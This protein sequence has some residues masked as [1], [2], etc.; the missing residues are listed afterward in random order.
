[1]I[2]TVYS[3]KFLIAEL[4][5]SPFF[6]FIKRLVETCF[7]EGYSPSRIRHGLG[8]IVRFVRWSSLRHL[9]V[10]NLR[11]K[12]VDEFLIAME[13][14]I[15]T[16]RVSGLCYFS[17]RFFKIVEDEVGQNLLE[18][19]VLNIGPHVKSQTDRYSKYLR[20]VRGLSEQSISR[21]ATVIEVFLSRRF[22]RRKI[23]LKRLIV[24][25]FI[26]F[27]HWRSQSRKP[28]TLQTEAAALK[29]MGSN[30]T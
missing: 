28:K 12:H 26:E 22:G 25:D 10:K 16:A 7:A 17:R 4:R 11:K 14:R 29:S 21:M 2:Q 1:M 23:N 19:H 30:E 27:M 8:G 18:Y 5:E 6:P 9:S 15:P 3:S 13:K 20:D 24:K